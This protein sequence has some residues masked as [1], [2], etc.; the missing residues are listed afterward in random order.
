M[1]FLSQLLTVLIAAGAVLYGMYLVILTFLKQEREKQDKELRAFSQKE[2][3]PIRLQAAERMCLL[4]E[5][6]RPNQLIRRVNDPEFSASQLHQ[7]LLRDLREE[8]N[9]NLSQQV[10]FSDEAWARV[11][12][13]VESTIVLIN[14]SFQEV[15]AQ[16]KGLVLAKAIMEKSL[17][18]S[19]ELSA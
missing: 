10:Y 13:A 7:A 4:L 15:D 5:R 6:I 2:V 9:H 3:I 11:E 16:A 12:A 19:A 17:A 18:S 14:A 1:E 8:V